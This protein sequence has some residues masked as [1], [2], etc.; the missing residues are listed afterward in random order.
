MIPYLYDYVN[1]YNGTRSPSKIHATDTWLARYFERYLIQQAFSVFKWELPETW[2]KNY[3]LYSLYC[4]GYLAIVK[5]D[6]FGVIP[7]ACSLSGHD[8]F[9]RPTTATIANPVL[10]GIMQPRIGRQCT[11]VRLQPDYGGIMD[12][13]SRYADLMALTMQT[14]GSNIL[15]SK[16]AYVFTAKNKA[17]AES[18]KK[19]IDSIMLGEPAVVID[20]KLK[21]DDGSQAWNLFTN[22]LHNNYIAGDLMQDLRKLRDGF[23]TEIGIPNSNT[24]KKER[25]LTD[26]VNSNNVE[27][28]SRVDMWLEELQ[29]SIKKSVEMFPEISGKFSVNWRYAPEV[30]NGNN[31][32]T[33]TLPTE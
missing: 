32:N 7:Q 29:E 3:F 1:A 33:R 18:F 19:M 14:A 26:E 6:K 16:L 23:C 28:F 4:F 24:E 10:K 27:T 22:N 31:I 15:S 8:V 20:D 30:T 5:T 13:V 9:Y 17:G 11:L 2:A 12:I 25:M 21:N